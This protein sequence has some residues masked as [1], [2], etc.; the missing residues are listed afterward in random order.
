L[1]VDAQRIVD[2]TKVPLNLH[3]E[4]SRGGTKPALVDIDQGIQLNGANRSHEA[5]IIKNEATN[6]NFCKTA[7]KPYDEVVTA[8]LLRAAHLAGDTIKVR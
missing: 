3:G 8:I 6:F 1:I 4:Y 5:F 7:R 2:T